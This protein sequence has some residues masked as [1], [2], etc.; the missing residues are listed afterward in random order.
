MTPL[1]TFEDLI[2]QSF[3]DLP[4]ATQDELVAELPDVTVV[5]DGETT[6]L[7]QLFSE[8]MSGNDAYVPGA[9]T[10]QYSGNIVLSNGK[11]V[12]AEL[13]AHAEAVTSDGRYTTVDLTPLGQD[14]SALSAEGVFEQ[15]APALQQIIGDVVPRYP[16][17]SSL[18]NAF[19]RGASQQ[20]ILQAPLANASAP[21]AYVGGVPGPDSALLQDEQ[22][23]QT[24]PVNGVSPVGRSPEQYAQDIA[25]AQPALD[26]SGYHLDNATE[27]IVLGPP[28]PGEVSPLDVLDST[29]NTDTEIIDKA[30]E[31]DPNTIGLPESTGEFPTAAESALAETVGVVGKAAGAVGKALVI[32]D[33]VGSTAKALVQLESGD[34]DGALLTMETMAGRVAGGLVGAEEGGIA[35]AELGAL[36]GPVGFAVGG[37]AGALVGGFVGSEVGSG[38]AGYIWSDA[39]AILQ[40]IEAAWAAAGDAVDIPADV[41]AL[42]DGTS[43]IVNAVDGLSVTLDFAGDY[44]DSGLTEVDMN[45]PDGTS[46]ITT[47]AAGLTI[48]TNFSAH[49]GTGTAESESVSSAKTIH[50]IT[51]HHGGAVANS[52]TI[53]NGGV[54]I[55]GGDG[56]VTNN[57]LITGVALGAGGSV[58]NNTQGT[59]RYEVGIDGGVGIVDN[60]GTVAGFV[61][62]SDGGSVSNAATGVVT[63]GVS[64]LYGSYG[65][66]TND[67]TVASVTINGT[68]G[69]SIVNTG[70]ISDFAAISGGGLVTNASGGYISGITIRDGSGTVRNTARATIAAEVYI[71]GGTAGGT[72]LVT[73]S[74][75]I[76]GIRISMSSGGSVVNESGA[77]IRFSTEILGGV[78]TITNYGT[79]SSLSLG[80]GGGVVNAAG[81]SVDGIF[82]GGATGTIVNDG[83]SSD[84]LRVSLTPQALQPATITNGPDAAALSAEVY[85]GA[86]AVFNQGS[87]RGVV[88]LADGGYLLNTSSAASIG[89]T[90]FTGFAVD[91]GGAPGTVVNYGTI[92]PGIGM[93]A[94][95][96]VENK[97]KAVIGR[98]G[99]SGS[100]PGTAIGITG[101]PATVSNQGTIHGSVLLYGGGYI[102]NN[103]GIDDAGGRYGIRAAGTLG[104]II[105]NEGY[106]GATGTSGHGIALSS[107][108]VLNDVDGVIKG[109]LYAIGWNPSQIASGVTVHN[110]GTIVGAVSLPSG[111]LVTNAAGATIIGAVALGVPPNG[112][113]ETVVNQGLI[114]GAVSLG[115]SGE[116]LGA[117]GY[118]GNGQG[119]TITGNAVVNSYTGL[120]VNHGTIGGKASAIGGRIVNAA[121]ASI[122][123][124]IGIGPAGGTLMNYGG[125][126]GNVFFGGTGRVVNESGQ[127]IAG[128]V[129]LTDGGYLANGA[130]A[131]ISGRDGVT[132][133]A[134]TTV[135]N[136]GTIAVSDGQYYS[137]LDLGVGGLVTNA[138]DGQIRGGMDGVLA[139]TSTVL[140]SGTIL[141]ATQAGIAL[142]GGSVTN[143]G[144]GVIAGYTAGVSVTAGSVFN[145]GY[146]GGYGSAAAGIALQPGGYLRNAAAA[147]IVGSQN[148][149]F[150]YGQPG[151]TVVNFGTIVE[152]SNYGAGVGGGGGMTLINAGT[153]VGTG[154]AVYLEPGENR[155]VV[156]PGAVFVGDV[157]GFG[158]T[159]EL[160]AGAERGTL[161][162]LDTSFTGFATVTF[163]DGAGWTVDVTPP[164]Y[165]IYGIPN[166]PAF[167]RF[168][169]GDVLDLKGVTADAEALSNGVLTLYDGA[170]PVAYLS[171]SLAEGSGGLMIAPDGAGG[172]DVTV[173]AAVPCYCRGTRILTPRGE[174]A[175][176]ELAIG[177]EVVTH[178]GCPRPIRWL[179]R[180]SYEGRFVAGNPAV[181]PIVV[182]AGALA[183]GI[184]ARDLWVSPEHALFVDGLLVPARHL[185]NDLTIIQT[186]SVETVEY[187]HI[188][189]AVHDV[190]FAEGAAAESFIDDGS[191]M[192][193]NNAPEFYALYPEAF[194]QPPAYCA[195]R[196]EDGL[197]LETIRDRLLRRARRSCNGDAVR[198]EPLRGYVDLVD[199]NRIKGWAFDP[200]EPEAAVTVAVLANGL[201][202]ARLVADRYREDLE[203]AGIGDGYHGFDWNIPGGLSTSTR[204]K[205]EIRHETDGSPLPGSPVVLRPVEAP[206]SAT[207]GVLRGALDTASHTRIAGWAQDM[208]D[209]ERPVGLVIEANGEVVARVVANRYRADLAEAGIGSGR[210]SF[211]V[212]LHTALPALQAQEIRVRREADGAELF[213]SPAI[214][215]AAEGF[216][217]VLEKTLGSMLANVA[218]AADEDRALR[219]LSRQ[220]D[221]LFARRAERQSG[222]EA[223]K[224]LHLYRR[225]YGLAT[226]G[227]PAVGSRR[228]ALVI[229][230]RVPE[231]TRDAGSVAILSHMRALRALGYEVS[232]VASAEIADD[233]G[234]ERLAAE[235]ITL[236]AAP[237]YSCVEDVLCRQAG[238]FDLVYAHRVGNA[239]KYLSLA[240]SHCPRARIV[241]SVADLHH[242]RFARQAEIEARPEL[243]AHSRMIAAREMLAARRADLVLTHSPAEADLLRRRVDAGKVHVVPFAVKSGPPPRP[244]ADRRGIAFIG[245]FVHAPNADAV[246]Y[247]LRDILPPAWKRDPTITCKIVGPDWHKD[248]LPTRDP[249]VEVVGP[250]DDL[251]K[252]LGGV[253]LAVAPLRFG[254]GVKGKVLDSFAASLPCVM[255]PIA[256][257]GLPLPAS[258]QQFAVSNDAAG[259]AELIVRFHIDRQVNQAA[260]RAGAKLV[261]REYSNMR[262]A[263][264]LRDALEGIPIRNR[265]TTAY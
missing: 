100:D 149:V 120:I 74:G 113:S 202:I 15:A 188:E 42:A 70:T 204:Q 237:Y 83:Y 40:G 59:I 156:D 193:F 60:A 226:D 26:E 238:T 241:Y 19:W 228:R 203:Q 154:T 30:A 98:A 222:R 253:R 199:H 109:T 46:E 107:G 191:R 218:T 185:V 183:D 9:A 36:F 207:L 174:V 186:E 157:V 165:P 14:I 171:L 24:D 99:L 184:P 176:E 138:V 140:N 128:Y 262:V 41:T 155:V 240:R 236:C 22:P 173:D 50:G 189:L 84:D 150:A 158:A 172:T 181:L 145:E 230:D 177:D 87:L 223:R 28:G 62:L 151:A 211:E 169:P 219:F 111:E 54:V 124:G 82:L 18:Q 263:E 52:G 114:N 79:A 20:F 81:A 200:A 101:G 245:G 122:A 77:V 212:L 256:A 247:L 55:V 23:L 123:G 201:V 117:S 254:A 232:F 170:A 48:T 132:G 252:I 16:P 196:V 2:R 246:H 206:V 51:L 63:G 104:A 21:N 13:F 258:L 43:E 3:A 163:D 166:Y 220:I 72:G 47:F 6:T 153:I 127:T 8:T 133:S 80:D 162:G 135:V 233:R 139:H 148:G 75:T 249:R 37:L 7:G 161:A 68:A 85:G 243:L 129:N 125:I 108:M 33:V 257:E 143:T 250:I 187:F 73:N 152:L 167:D 164:A 11:T 110:Y 27:K 142:Y 56:S 67:G 209:R 244:F 10:L 88:L 69:G 192:M 103:G 61:R 235:N 45:R 216:D 144:S 65:S 178:A 194:P 180:R 94:G 259:L 260:G 215:P 34:A 168:A 231:A 227:E 221:Q 102:K 119:A 76:G 116:R 175:V 39:S 93:S 190:I 29:P 66:V 91:V 105:V 264:A 53:D 106:I 198:S 64:I 255:T 126:A 115:E 49:D 57:G 146:I 38:R 112:R 179:G 248:K 95:G 136:N 134:F 239:D 225:R 224:A 234:A 131:L 90:S 35:G 118:I 261:E 159:L 86:G 210:H 96:L 242:L 197:P 31:I 214:L 147:T 121:G 78:G 5:V 141:G 92:A 137:A 195:P 229:D 97:L 89:N 1:F 32:A 12:A 4:Q 205:I 208:A 58:S 71:L 213:G 217:P 251:D 130:S 182:A 160:A 25:A 44:D 265:N 17:T